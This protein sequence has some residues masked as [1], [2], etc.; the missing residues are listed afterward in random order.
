M[1]V[2]DCGEDPLADGDS[3][4]D[5]RVVKSETLM[6]P[7]AAACTGCHDA[8]AVTAHAE[9]TTTASGAEAC[10]VCHGPGADHD[11]QRVHQLAP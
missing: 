1:Q 9:T 6:Y 8:P 5:A 11:V 3:Y 4:C 7:A 10:A 2:L